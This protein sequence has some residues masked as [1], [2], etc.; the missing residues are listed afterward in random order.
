[1]I[2]LVSCV[3]MSVSEIKY[4]YFQTNIRRQFVRSR[5][6]NAIDVHTDSSE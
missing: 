4:V 2:Y 1:M 6:K 5:V 3:R